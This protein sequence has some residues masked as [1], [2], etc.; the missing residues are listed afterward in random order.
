MGLPNNEQYIRG[1]A[2]ESAVKF[3]EAVPEVVAPRK[4]G[5][6]RISRLLDLADQ[7]T[8]YIEVGRQ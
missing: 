3:A 4:V 1:M 8:K 5:E 7:F 6:T 2:L